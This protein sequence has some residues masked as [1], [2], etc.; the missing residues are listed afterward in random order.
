MHKAFRVSIFFQKLLICFLLLLSSPASAAGPTYVGGTYT[1]SQTWTPDGSPYIVTSD[2][3]FTNCATLTITNVRPGGGEA[4][5]EIKFNANTG[6]RFGSGAE[7]AKS[8]GILIARGSAACPIIFTTNAAGKYWK[9]VS[10]RWNPQ[11]S[12]G[13]VSSLRYCIIEYGGVEESYQMKGTVSLACSDAQLEHCTIRNSLH[14]GIHLNTI[15][16]NTSCYGSVTSCQI[17]GNQGSGINVQAAAGSGTCSPIVAGNEI[18]NNGTYGIY[19]SSAQCNPDIRAGNTISGNSSYPLRIPAIMRIDQNNTFSGNGQQAIEVIG[20]TIFE[21]KT[22][23]NFGIPYIVR[24]K[25]ITIPDGAGKTLTLTIEPGTVVKF[26]SGIGLRLGSGSSVYSAGYGILNAQ[27]TQEKPI[28]FSSIA[29]GQYWPGIRFDWSSSGSGSRLNYCTIEYAGAHKTQYT[30]N[31]FDGALFFYECLPSSSTIQ[32]STVRYSKSDGIRFYCST[33]GTVTLHH[34]N[35][36]A[37][38]LYDI[39]DE[40]RKAAVNAELNFWG[41]PNGPGDDFCSSAAVSSAVHYEPW[42]EDAFTEPLRFISASASPKQFEPLTGHTTITFTLSQSAAWKLSIVNQQL[43]TVWSTTGSSAGDAVTW[44]GV[45]SSGG[46]VSG[47]CFYRIEAENSSGVAAPARGILT[48]GN[49][50]IARITQPAAGTIFNP[51]TRIVISGT[52]QPGAGE[53][54][55]IKYGSGE[56]PSSW[57]SIS[58]PVYSS[59]LNAELA[60][61][62][63]AGI[64]QPSGT[65]KLEVHKAGAVYT[66]IVRIGFFFTESQ[67][68]SDNAVI[69]RYDALGRLTSAHYPDGSSISYTY[70]RT[71]NRLTVESVGQTAPTAIRISSFSAAATR[72]GIVVQWKTETEVHTA[73]FNLYRKAAKERDYLKINTSLIQS[74]GSA[75]VGAAYSYTD[76]PPRAGSA[77][78]YQLEEVETSGTTNRY[79]PVSTVNT[80]LK[81]MG[82]TGVFRKALTTNCD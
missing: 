17:T 14:D 13:T 6:M 75:T 80:A 27:G 49:Q 16:A 35:F 62:D 53:Y 39:I 73:G 61:W 24:E 28:V 15:D 60:A 37:N 7:Y 11:A 63:T 21:N 79:G 51:G 38:S 66:D 74:R 77:W 12:C 31:L 4:P 23:H 20:R 64:D 65:V 55:E 56:N 59:K 36:Y 2:L 34:N 29:A 10:F 3:I 42:L 22:W 41:T 1:A 33:A 40:T 25:D 54:Y 57:S 8:Y 70:D 50:T 78:Y 58:G 45:S 52:A 19:C 18:T 68:S 48:A 67:E 76:V 5:V 69:Y 47:T 82:G 46:V 71:G 32:H 30:N 9:G 43:E 81:A 26:D 44:N 72:Q